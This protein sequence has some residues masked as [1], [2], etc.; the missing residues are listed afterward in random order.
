MTM[1]TQQRTMSRSHVRSQELLAHNSE[2]IPGGLA[3][4]NRKTDP[5]IAFARAEGSR[6]WDLDG[7]EYIDY[8][9]GFA[10]Y[11]LGHN[12]PDQN[13]AVIAAVQSGHSNYG[14]G[15]TE[16]E[17]ELAR[18]FLACLPMAEKVQFFNTGSEATAQA[19]RISRS[20]TG[21]DHVIRFQG[22][23]NGNQNVVATNLMTPAAAL[24]GQHAGGEYPVVPITAGIPRSE[25]DLLHPVP[26][27]DLAAVEADA[28]RSTVNTLP[29][30]SSSQWPAEHRTCVQASGRAILQGFTEALCDQ[31]CRGADFR[32][33]EDGVPSVA[34]RISGPVRH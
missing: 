27:N 28:R 26:F 12:D 18:L 20:F 21:R 23:Y 17:G 25:L 2:V 10:P 14:S 3:S 7:N 30:S 29:A 24:G 6:M 4:I 8:H 5:V 22:G 1:T 19:I 16:D 32:R 11:L 33:G 15:P 9:A 13:R 34:R 31:A